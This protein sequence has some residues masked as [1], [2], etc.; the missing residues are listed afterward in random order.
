[1]SCAMAF[2]F[3][4]QLGQRQIGCVVCPEFFRTAFF[5]FFI[6]WIS[7]RIR[8]FA[9]S[10]SFYDIRTS[11]Y[12]GLATRVR[13]LWY[14][15]VHMTFCSTCSLSATLPTSCMKRLNILLCKFTFFLHWM[16]RIILL[17]N[18]FSFKFSV[19]CCITKCDLV[20]GTSTYPV[21]CISRQYPLFIVH[22]QCSAST[23][24][25]C[26]LIPFTFCSTCY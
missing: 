21:I 26:K 13:V 12:L 17:Y 18:F 2:Q 4:R 10:R 22:S 5:V 9:L 24:R 8:S 15:S 25:I 11:S 19:L 6:Y 7:F 3:S 1:M 14:L 20:L 23:V 16:L